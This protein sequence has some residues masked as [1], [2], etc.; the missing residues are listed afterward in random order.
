MLTDGI[1][2]ARHHFGWHRGYSTDPDADT[3]AA[4]AQR[5]GTNVFAIYAP[6]S[7]LYRHSYWQGIN[8]QTNLTRLTDQTGGASF[9]LGL[10]S[11]VT[12][13]PYLAQLQTTLDNQYLLSFSL[14]SGKKPG[15][16]AV[17]LSTDLAGVD[18]A[19]HDAVW[20]AGGK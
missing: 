13:Q 12:I 16:Q 10:H 9:Y 8:G 7:A 5:T 3:A 15:L 4:V 20:V 11:P 17:N 18:L 19:A 6:A 14:K 2:R 1:G